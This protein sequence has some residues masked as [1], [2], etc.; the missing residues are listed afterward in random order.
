MAT[1]CSEATANIAGYAIVGRRTD[2][3]LM[4]PPVQFA[5]VNGLAG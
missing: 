2:D 1:N 4:A 5:V 3:A